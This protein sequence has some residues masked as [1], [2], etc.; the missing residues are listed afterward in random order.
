MSHHFDLKVVGLEE[1]EQL[2]YEQWPTR[3]ISLTSNE[4]IYYG[5]HHLHVQVND[6]PFVAKHA[7]SPSLN[8]LLTVLNFTKDLTS[9]DRLLVH[10]FAGQSRST[11]IAIAIMIQHGLSYDAAFDHV[12]AVRNILMPNQLFIKITDDHFQLG[13]KLVAYATAHRSSSLQRTLV[14]PSGPPSTRDVDGM[15]RIMRMFGNYV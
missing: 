14:L 5:P 3:I 7:M 8:H 15:K 12:E 6:V 9:R 13:G 10:C 1:A 2:F 11:A 4:S